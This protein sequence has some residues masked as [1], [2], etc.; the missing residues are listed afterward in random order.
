MKREA[1]FEVVKGHIYQIIPE[2]KG[3]TIGD[4]DS[5]KNLG[6]DSMERADILVMTLES[7]QL[8]TPRVDFAD[9]NTLGELV[10]RLAL[11]LGNRD[12]D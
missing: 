2:L 4:A 3:H 6:L 8:E 1:I 7:L 11:K 10:D 9:S 12:D 5:M